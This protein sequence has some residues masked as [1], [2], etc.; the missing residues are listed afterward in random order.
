MTTADFIALQQLLGISRAEFCRRIGIA[1]NSG[2]AYA[3]GR[4]PI[5]R[6]VAMA[7]AALALGVVDPPW[8]TEA[9]ADRPG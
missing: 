6:T 9:P 4:K 2:T 8:P 1:E 7:C 3:L 5:P